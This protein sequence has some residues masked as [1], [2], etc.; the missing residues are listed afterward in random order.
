MLALGSV[1][2]A[3]G[4][5]SVGADLL[6]SATELHSTGTHLEMRK[7]FRTSSIP[8]SA[9]GPFSVIRIGNARHVVFDLA[10][11]HR[12][13]GVIGALNAEV[14]GRNAFVDF[15]YPAEELCRELE[16]WRREALGNG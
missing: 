6:P 16:A 7:H 2:F 14:V 15:D 4:A 10:P 11:P 9:C 1:F 5:V 3:V 8:W 12:P 13:T